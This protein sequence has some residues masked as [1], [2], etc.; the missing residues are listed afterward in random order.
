[1]SHVMWKPVLAICEQQRCRSACAS[2]Q[3][4]QHLCCSLPRQYDISSFYIWNFKPLASCCG[5]AGRFESYVVENPKTGFLATRL[6]YGRVSRAM[7]DVQRNE[8]RHKK[9]C[10]ATRL[11]HGRVT[12]AM[13]DVQRNEPRHEKTCLRGLRPGKTQTGLLSYGDK[14]EAWDCAYRNYRY[15]TI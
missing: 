12:R 11:K 1:M 8:P 2:A 7:Y 14:P 15:Y 10:L 3:S 5:C 9:T 13:Y 4:D 6:K